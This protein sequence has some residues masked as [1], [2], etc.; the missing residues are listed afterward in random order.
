MVVHFIRVP[1]FWKVMESQ[2]IQ[3]LLESQG[4]SGNFSLT[5]TNFSIVLLVVVSGGLTA[6]DISKS[7]MQY[8][9][10]SHRC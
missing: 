2:G 6:I 4:K 7:M 1:T 3:K 9:H 8:V 5:G 10:S